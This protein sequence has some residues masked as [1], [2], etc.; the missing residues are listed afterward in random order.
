MT[1]KNS[2]ILPSKEWVTSAVILGWIAIWLGLFEIA[3]YLVVPY[4]PPTQEPHAIQKYLE[5]GRSVEGKIRTMVGPTDKTTVPVTLTGWL[6]PNKQEQKPTQPKVPGGMLIAIYGM[7]FAAHVAEALA[8]VEPSITT[9]FWGGPGAGPN[10][11]Y[12]AYQLDRG[13]HTAPVVLF[14]ISASSIAE[15]TTF[16]S[17]NKTFEYPIPYTYPKYRRVG[18][19][20]EE[21]WPAVRTMAD[22]RRVLNDQAQWE[23]YVA[24]MKAEDSFFQPFVFY[25]NFLDHWALFRFIRRSWAKRQSREIN[26]SFY[27]SKGFIENS[28]PIQALRLIVKEFAKQVRDDGKLPIVMLFNNRGYHDHLSKVL[29]STLQEHQIPT[30]N[31]HEIA[32]SDNPKNIASDAFHFSRAV[33]E[34]FAHKILAIIRDQKN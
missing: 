26:A 13:Q 23:K 21:F 15:M 4:N 28:Q 8:R 10:H 17:L 16:T 9:R 2:S 14:G 18:D 7:S 1:L 20:L 27:N 22:F 12:K 33:N 5:Y 19:H 31:S 11:T 32:P 29:A 6:D 34:K 3:L 25:E 30:M 24:A